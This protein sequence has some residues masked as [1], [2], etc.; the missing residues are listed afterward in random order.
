MKDD[1]YIALISKM[2][3]GEITTSEFKRR[4]VN[5]KEYLMALIDSVLCGKISFHQFNELYYPFVLEL[6][7]NV[8]DERDEGFFEVIRQK[9]EWTTEKP[10]GESIKYGWI[11][12]EQFVEWLGEQKAKYVVGE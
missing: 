4:T 3:S 6:L 5:P 1:G 9:L 8:L 11:N 12:H 10:D 7:P 2:V